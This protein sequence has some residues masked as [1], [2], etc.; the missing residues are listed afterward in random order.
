MEEIEQ[1]V[2][3]LNHRSFLESRAEAHEGAHFSVPPVPMPSFSS[4]PSAP[5]LMGPPNSVSFSD[6]IRFSSLSF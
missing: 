6:T 3:E 1:D 5:P 2:Q 4:F